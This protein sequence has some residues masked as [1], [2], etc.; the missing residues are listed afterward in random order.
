MTAAVIVIGYLIAQRITRPLEHLVSAS[1][2]IAEGDLSYRTG[3]RGTDEIGLLATT[4][5]EMA[6]RLLE[7]TNALEETLGQPTPTRTPTP[8]STPTRTPTPT[9]TPPPTPVPFELRAAAGNNEVSLGWDAVN[10]PPST[11]RV[12]RADGGPY[13]I[14]TETPGTAYLDNSVVNG[15]VYTYYV[16]ALDAEGAEFGYSN[17]AQVQPYDI[18]PYT[19]TTDVTCTPTNPNRWASRWAG[20][21]PGRRSVCRSG[22]R[23]GN[24]H[25]R[26]PRP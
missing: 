4:F 9:A 24:R 6:S 18:T 25:H 13:I 15:T 17:L 11:Y 22:L 10:P 8:T 5:D 19:T 26:R 16:A 23:R 20:A 21:E 7:R 1:Q 2:A 3:I 12:Y 14:V